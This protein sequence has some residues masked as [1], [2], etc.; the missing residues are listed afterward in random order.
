MKLRGMRQKKRKT[1]FL[2]TKTK[3]HLNSN[4]LLSLFDLCDSNFYL[5][6]VLVL[7]SR[8]NEKREMICFGCRFMC[9]FINSKFCIVWI[10]LLSEP[11]QLA[12]KV[13]RLAQITMIEH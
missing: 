3:K 10:F 1:K 8:R 13:F 2:Y 12:G 4:I 7:C 5:K 9:V 6:Y 11:N